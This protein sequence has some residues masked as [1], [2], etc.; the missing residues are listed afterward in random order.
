MDK[1][2]QYYEDQAFQSEFRGEY[3]SG[4][5]SVSMAQ[6]SQGG[7]LPA[8]DTQAYVQGL[9]NQ[10]MSKASSSAQTGAHESE[11]NSR[12]GSMPRTATIPDLHDQVE[13]VELGP[14]LSQMSYTLSSSRSDVTD[15]DTSLS[16]HDAALYPSTQQYMDLQAY[17]EYSYKDDEDMN[18]G[19]A[20]FSRRSTND[21]SRLPSSL[22]P[23]T[24]ESFNLFTNPGDDIMFSPP[25]DMVS[26]TLMTSKYVQSQDLSAMEPLE[27]SSPLILWNGL[28]SQASRIS[29]PEQINGDSWS[30]DH[31][32]GLG[33]D[34]SLEYLSSHESRISGRPA[35]PDDPSQLYSLHGPNSTYDDMSPS[36]QGLANRNVDLDNTARDHPLYQKATPKADG[37]YHCPWEGDSTCTHKPEKLKCNYDK[38]VDSHLKPYRCKVH[39]CENARFS[40]TAC[41]LRHERE[42]HAMHGHGEKPFL[43][44][45]EG[46]DRGIPG[47]G[48]PR[49]WNL[50]DHMKRVHNRSPSPSA[51]KPQ[52]ARGGRKR[53]N[54]SASEGAA[55]KKSPPAQAPAQRVEPAVLELSLNEQW[56]QRRVQL[57]KTVQMIK[58]PSDA[59][60]L[61]RLENASHCLKSM[62]D[63]TQMIHSAPEMART[64]SQQSG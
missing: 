52:A 37:L 4:D 48:F 47:N 40:S 38:F 46:C 39:A 8:L 16:L 36:A 13:S 27:D 42:A 15:T 34:L 3:P 29:S 43:C 51:G 6:L 56:E 19:Y 53:K 58:D 12:R 7:S 49:H 21:F 60:I 2:Q 22:L 30:V 63:T 54:E 45:S 1:G 25:L 20:S 10:W 9:P 18:Q 17:S 31:S 62:H 33:N 64:K 23:L 32:T 50:C 26:P 57:I 44:T 61:Q 5:S 55:A 28:E 59:A 14:S 11:H 41:L 35:S 24:A